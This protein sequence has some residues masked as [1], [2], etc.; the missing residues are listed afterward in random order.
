MEDVAL[1]SGALLS[2]GRYRIEEKRAAGGFGIVY[3]ALDVKRGERV[4]V[5]ELFWREHALREES[6]TV[7]LKDEKDAQEYA[8]VRAAFDAEAKTLRLLADIP[9]VVHVRD[10]FEENGTAYIVMDHVEGMTLAR[11][12]RERAKEKKPDAAKCFRRFLPLMQSIAKVHDTGIIHRDVSPENIIVSA[13]GSYTLIDFGSAGTYERAAEERFT[14]IAKDGFAPEEQYREGARQGPYSDVYGLCATVYT[15]LTGTVPDS[16]RARRIMDD[17]KAPSLLGVKVPRELEAVLMR[18]LA[19]NASKRYT[20][21]HALIAAVRRALRAR[22]IRAVRRTAIAALAAV[23]IGLGAWQTA[24]FLSDDTTPAD[25]RIQATWEN[26]VTMGTPGKNQ[27]RAAALRGETQAYLYTFYGM[28]RATQGEREDLIRQMKARLDTLGTP[29]AFDAD[30]DGNGS[31]AIRMAGE[32]ISDF[33]LSTLTDN[34]LYVRG[35]D[36]SASV[37]IS[38]NRYAKASDLTVRYQEDGTY[39]LECMIGDDAY[40]EDM[41]ARMRE[42]GEDTLYLCDDHGHAL[43]QAP[44]S[45]LKD[46]VIVFTSLRFENVQQMNADT[47]FMADYIQ[48]LVNTPPLPFIGTLERKEMLDTRGA[49]QKDV[50]AQAGMILPRTPADQALVDVLKKI[51]EDTGYACTENPD[52]TL[53]ISVDLPV[54]DTLPERAAQ[55]TDQLLGGYPLSGQT[56]NHSLII[57]LIDEQEHE[58]L[59][60]ALGRWFALDGE[61]EVENM[62]SGMLMVSPRLEP[63]EEALNAWWE[64]LPDTYHG[65]SV[66]K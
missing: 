63:Y 49:A 21:M 41:M 35:E 27:V 34:Y 64:G 31:V 20:D 33:V 24:M 46:G 6:G 61:N 32:R 48:A 56:Y 66:D 5:K 54:D 4:A 18:G 59:R 44:V 13:K 1:K 19:V 58:L 3:A 47:R 15:C 17:V 55:V 25:N 57:T 7:R 30:T 12:N 50:Y 43:A 23:C 38:Y 42:R 52:G 53:F 37:T 45:A 2:E 65:F 51:H 8:S 11:Q 36:D 62:A 22:V 40:F 16:A 29:Y 28:E 9:G 60:V 10:T 39:A 26:P 14:T